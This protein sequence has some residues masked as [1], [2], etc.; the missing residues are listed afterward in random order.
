MKPN[1]VPVLQ[2]DNV[3]AA[4][5]F[6]VRAFGF[7]RRRLDTTPAGAIARAELRFA[8][9]A[10]CVRSASAATGPW[11]GIRHAIHVA[12][13]SMRDLT[14]RDPG[15]FFWSFGPDDMGAG[16]GEVT[17][18]PEL[19]YRDIV[20]ATAWLHEHFGFETTFKVPGPD[21]A[22]VHVEMRLGDG[23][24]YVGPVSAKGSFADVTQFVNLVVND[25]DAHHAH[26][27]AAGANVVIAPRDTPFGARFYAVRDPENALWWLST[28]QP[29]KP[30]TA[31]GHL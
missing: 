9:G 13:T 18:V 10:L 28:Y 20:S 31:P 12:T 21:G 26:A 27:V 2:Y 4:I 8:S 14:T 25:P 6:L 15:G 17:I 16:E 7:T 24:I 1:I 3:Q 23:A 30:G 19:R 11:A 22:P 5:E 29:A